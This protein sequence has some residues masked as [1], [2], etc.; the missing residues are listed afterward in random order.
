MNSKIAVSVLLLGTIFIMS[1]NDQLYAAHRPVIRAKKSVAQPKSIIEQINI[2]INTN[3]T[4]KAL[5]LLN[6]AVLKDPYNYKLFS[7][8]ANLFYKNSQYSEAEM[9][10]RKAIS[11]NPQ[12]NNCYLILGNVLLQN[13]KANNLYNE[14]P[15]NEQDKNLLNE[16]LKCFNTVQEND[17]ASALPHIGL[18]KIY[19]YQN[20]QIKTYDELLKAKELAGEN[21]NT[22]FEL[23][24]LFYSLQH[25]EKAIKYL[26][27]SISLSTKDDYKSH[28]LLAEIYEKLGSYKEAQDEYVATLKANIKLP[29]VKTKTDESDQKIMQKSSFNISIEKPVYSQNQDILQADDLLIMDRFSEA[30]DLYLK[31]LHQ[32]PAYPDALA[33]I[34]EL[35]YAQWLSG[36]YDT[37]KY[38][39]DNDYFK[40]LP[41]NKFKFILIKFSLVAE[42][43]ISD[44]IRT[45]LK[46][47]A[48][49][50]SIELYD[51]FDAARSI[52]LLENYLGSK[53]KLQELTDYIEDE[54]RLKMAKLLYLDRNYPEAERLIRKIKQPE[55]S[56]YVRT[57]K[58]RIFFKQNLANEIFEQGLELYK[59]EKY[60]A[61]IIKFEEVLKLF[62][63]HKKT[64]LYYAYSLQKEGNLKKAIEELNLYKNFELLY[65]ASKPELPLREVPKL[66]KSWQIKN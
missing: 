28:A 53:I 66:I 41:P 56:K 38:Y 24:E 39:M 10:A 19:S 49:N 48:M 3:E 36:H 44:S 1:C 21:P 35:Y 9:L 22:L 26:K 30:R 65:P 27:K 57:L 13:Y 40:N 6:K 25:Y 46:K 54:D 43:E 61:A 60:N 63:T 45:S 33:G 5:N 17:P 51:Q 15:P 34:S 7:I 31:V 58:N 62:P 4:Q 2:Y 52:F 23:A 47:V 8:G 11:L 64:H 16:S 20:N 59:R 32:N 37:K 55:Y 18:A 29:D 50:K 42:P 12:D 14:Y